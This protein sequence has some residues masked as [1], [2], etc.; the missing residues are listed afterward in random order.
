[1]RKP[2]VGSLPAGTSVVLSVHWY[3]GFGCLLGAI[4]WTIT[5]GWITLTWIKPHR[6]IEWILQH[7][8]RAAEQAKHQGKEAP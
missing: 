7:Y 2:R 8:E 1:M 6:T 5:L 3:D 4:L